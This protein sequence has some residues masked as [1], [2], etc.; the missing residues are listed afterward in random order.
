MKKR[1]FVITTIVLA[2]LLAACTPSVRLAG[3]DI[4]VPVNL[5]GGSGGD[6]GGGSAGDN[7]QQSAT[8]T[9]PNVQAGNAGNLDSS[10]KLLPGNSFPFEDGFENFSIGQVVAVAAPQN[11]GIFRDDGSD[12]PSFAKIEET[13]DTQGQAG[14]AIQINSANTNPFNETQGVLTLGSNNSQN[15]RVNF[16][17][18]ADLVSR[19]FLTL[20]LN[21]G[22][23]GSAYYKVTIDNRAGSVT[24]DKVL[25]DQV[26]QVVNRDQ[27]GFNYADNIFR[28]VEIISQAGTVKVVIDGRTLIDYSDNDPNYQTGGFG[29]GFSGGGRLFIDNLSVD[30]L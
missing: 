3:P 30:Q 7:N 23:G 20:R 19:S 15:Y 13:F 16:D 28:Q 5:G 12:D 22:A 4:N 1:L 29:I 17:F 27:M 24:L 10:I 21:I 9:S 14:K 2:V 26:V 18:K 11:Y 8:P 6:N 25:G